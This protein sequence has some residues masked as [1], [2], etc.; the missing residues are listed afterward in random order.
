MGKRMIVAII[1]AVVL[2]GGGYVLLANSHVDI[3][4]C[5]EST[6]DFETKKLTT[7]DHTC[8]ILDTTRPPSPDGEKAELTAAGWGVL[9]AVDV[10][11]PLVIGFAVGGM[12]VKKK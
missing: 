11:L 12:V 10:L 6:Y 2:G 7:Q 1:I 4:P 8:S 5:T 9:A 3:F